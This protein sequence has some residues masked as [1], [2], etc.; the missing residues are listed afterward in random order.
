MKKE[1]ERKRARLDAIK[2]EQDKIQ[3]E[4]DEMAA[5]NAGDADANKVAQS[6]R[7]HA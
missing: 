4:R 6:L 1:A 5:K 7:Q 3:A 2:A